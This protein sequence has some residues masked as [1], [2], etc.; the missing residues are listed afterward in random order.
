M[1]GILSPRPPDSEQYS[2]PRSPGFLPPVLGD[3]DFI[4]QVQTGKTLSDIRAEIRK[5]PR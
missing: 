3:L 2:E 5:M 1:R 4:P